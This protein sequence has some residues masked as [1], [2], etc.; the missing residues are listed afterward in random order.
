MM[1]TKLAVA[2][3]DIGQAPKVEDLAWSEGVGR[4]GELVGEANT[5]VWGGAACSGDEA[6][7]SGHHRVKIA[8]DTTS[9]LAR[10]LSRGRNHAK[11]FVRVGARVRGLRWLGWTQEHKNYAEKM[12]RFILVW[13][14]SVPTS[15]S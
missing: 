1:W 13:A 2:V 3:D 15:S 5:P 8:L 6:G 10:Q 9:Y 12:Q 14:N 4:N 7:G 11:N